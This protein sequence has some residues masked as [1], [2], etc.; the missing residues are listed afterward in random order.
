MDGWTHVSA[1]S[2]SV[3]CT[4][5][6]NVT[7]VA[8]CYTLLIHVCALGLRARSGTYTTQHAHPNA[9]VASGMSMCCL[10]G[11]EG[12][13]RLGQAKLPDMLT[14]PVGSRRGLGRVLAL[15]RHSEVFDLG[16][17]SVHA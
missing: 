13:V 14:A 6:P 3:K 11:R 4:D 15:A 2:T 17:G 1:T 5:A 16:L 7:L 9:H 8:A 10:H 12:K